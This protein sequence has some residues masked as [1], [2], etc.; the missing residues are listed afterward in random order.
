MKFLSSTIQVCRRLIVYLLYLIFRLVV[1][2]ALGFTGYERRSVGTCTVLAPVEK[3]PTILEGIELLRTLDPSMFRCLTVE[4]SYCFLYSNKMGY[5]QLFEYFI[6]TDKFLRRGKDGVAIFCVQCILDYELLVL[7][8][9][10]NLSWRHRDA[11]KARSKIQQQMFN[12]V[13][14]YP[15]PAELV[16]HYKTLAERWLSNELADNRQAAGDIK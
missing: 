7:P 16:Q 1:R 10:R 2:L 11:V 15:F 5:E 8:K 14:Q 3:M 13:K 4:Q 12:W 9:W 6:I